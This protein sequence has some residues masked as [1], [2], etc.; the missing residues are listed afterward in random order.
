MKNQQFLYCLFF[1]ILSGFFSAC[2]DDG[3]EPDQGII[4]QDGYFIINEG[5]FGNANTSVSYFERESGSVSNSVFADA[6]SRPLG[7]QTQSMTVFDGRG[8]IVVQN[9]S[10]VEVIDREDFTSIA[11]IGSEE[12]IASPRYFL[13]I[14]EDKGYV[15][16]WGADG[17]SGT[18]KVI[19]LNT[20]TVTKSI[21]TGSGPN[22]LILHNGRVYVA[23][24]GG[25]GLDST[26]VV[27]NPQSD[28]VEDE[29]VVGDNPTSL[30]VDAGGRIWV[31][32]SGFAFYDPDNNFALDES[33]STP[34][35]L[36]RLENNAVS[37]KAEAE[38]IAAG[39][40]GVVADN[41]G[42][43][44]YYRYTGGIFRI[45]TDATELAETPFISGSFYGLAID[46][47]SG[48]ILATD[49]LNFSDDGLFYRYS[50]D[51]DLIESYT[52][53]IAPNGFAF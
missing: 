12:G 26:V 42:Q 37:F 25:F 23:N 16:D 48:E 8:F 28:E 21:A 44:L 49:P 45:S 2:N 14:S 22:Q 10:K 15:T 43:Q 4:A 38:Q 17:L 6:N 50:T 52:V 41:S 40:S 3:P 51:G 39:P 5:G 47:L 7:D 33:L 53:G 34:G 36:A 11:T 29:I 24:G 31:A 35:F 9:S 20:Y 32:G 1:V 46:P 18:V 30:T 19:D 13:G 27:I